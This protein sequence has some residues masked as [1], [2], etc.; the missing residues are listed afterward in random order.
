[1]I[2]R[3]RIRVLSGLSVKLNLLGFVLAIVACAETPTID[4]RTIADKVQS[5]L[6][7]DTSLQ[8]QQI[9][10]TT[11]SGIVQLT[12]MVD[13][14]YSAQKAEHYAKRVEGVKGV[15]NRLEVGSPQ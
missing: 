11:H 7:H 5:E 4:D 2:Y 1:M 3:E 9:S 10:V 15:K 14:G 12:G 13:S 6:Y 8:G